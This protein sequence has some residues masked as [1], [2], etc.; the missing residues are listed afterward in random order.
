MMD[1]HNILP[2]ECVYVG[3][4]PGDARAAKGRGMHFIASLESGLKRK[5]DFDGLLVDLF[6]PR[7]VD[8]VEAVRSLDR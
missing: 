4:T 8:V 2:E 3:D 1:T 7:F 6:I 5:E